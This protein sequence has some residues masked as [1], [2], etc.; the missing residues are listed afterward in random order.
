M[1]GAAKSFLIGSTGD[2]LL[3]GEALRWG[4]FAQANWKEEAA[5]LHPRG[6]RG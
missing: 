6:R 1:A 5:G 2:R 3:K 4:N